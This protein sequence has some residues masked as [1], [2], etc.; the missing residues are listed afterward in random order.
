MAGPDDLERHIAHL[1]RAVDDLSDVVA[2]QAR[3]IAALERKVALL[4]QREAEREAQEAGAL[5]GD[6]PPP[7][8]W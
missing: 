6:E 1:E 8:H 3:E 2:R 5:P 7:P 4:L